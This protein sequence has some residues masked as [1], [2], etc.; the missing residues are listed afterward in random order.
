VTATLSPELTARED[1]FCFRRSLPLKLKLHEVI[2]ALGDVEGMTCLDVGAENGMLSYHLRRRGG[3]WHSVTTGLKSMESVA[4]AVSDNVYLFG[5]KDLPFDKGTFDAV[6]V[7][8]YHEGV[9][10]DASFIE[11]CHRVLKPDGRLIF[12]VNH[13]KPW[14]L[15]Y[16]VRRLLGQAHEGRGAAANGYTESRLFATLKDGFNVHSMR[17]FSRFLLELVVAVVE[18]LQGRSPDGEGGG[19]RGTRRLYSIAAVF[20]WLAYQLDMLFFFTRGH[21]IIAT[22]KRRVWRPRKTPV[23]VGGRSIGEAVLSRAAN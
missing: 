1:F 4:T 3:D 5:G 15:L 8:G 16:V 7:F 2:R 19:R 11:E 23:L 17:T 20:Y 22:A 13:A 14:S 9:P 10:S 18:S 21:V 6:V 12:M